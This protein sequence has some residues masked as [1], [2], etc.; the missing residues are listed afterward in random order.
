MRAV[1]RTSFPHGLLSKDKTLVGG[2]VLLP[3]NKGKLKRDG[4]KQFVR[5]SGF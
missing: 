1:S 2:M 5:M 3:L 4:V